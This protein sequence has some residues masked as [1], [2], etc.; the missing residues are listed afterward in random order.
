MTAPTVEAPAG[1]VTF[2]FT[3]IEGSTRLIHEMGDRYVDLLDRH[4]ELL[5][6]VWASHSGYEVHNDG[7]AFLVAFADAADGVR[8]CA[9]AQHRLATEPWPD[10]VDL[11]VRIGVHTG[12]AS[13]HGDDYV[14]L[15][16]HQAARVV[17]AAHGGLVLVSQDTIDALGSV[18]EPKLEPI[19]RYRLRDFD[20]PLQ[21]YRLTG[22][23]FAEAIP[24]IRAVPADGHNIV[25]L[26]TPTIGREELIAGIADH[27]EAGRLLTLIG[28]GGVGKTRVGAEVG[29]LIASDWP[30]GVWRVDLAGVADGDLVAAAI[31]GAIGARASRGQQRS[32]DVLDHL[33][34]RRA[35]V[36]LDNVEHV[37][38]ACR[39]LVEAIQ[40]RCRG[41]ALIAGSRVPIHV[42]GE[43]Q[44]PVEPLDVPDPS[45]HGADAVLASSSGRLFA[46]RGA[47]VRPGFVVDDNN[48]ADIAK[49]CQR[50][51]GLPLSLELA[52]THLAIQSPH[53]ILAGIDERFQLLRSHDPTMDER[54]RDVEGM[55]TWSYQSLD[56][57]ERT[58]FRCVSVFGTGFSILTAQAAMG[59]ADIELSEVPMLIWSLVD[60]SLVV[61]DLSANATRYRLLETMRTFGRRL[62]DEQGETGPVAVGVA[63]DLMGRIGPWFAADRRWLGEVGTEIDNLRAMIGFVPAEDQELAQQIA[64]TIGRYHDT[65]Q[66]F[67][68][69]IDELGRYVDTLSTPTPTRVSLLTT[70]ADLYLRT[71]NVDA[72]H[73]L[74]AEATALHGELGPTDWDDVGVDRTMGEVARRSGDLTGAIRIAR[75]TLERPLSDRGRSRM[76]NLLGTTSAATGEFETAYEAFAAELEVNK[77]LGYEGVVASA[78]GNLAEVAMRLGDIAA[79]ARHQAACLDLAVAQ[80]STTMLAFSLIVAA[81]IAGSQGEPAQATRLHAQGEV[82]LAETGLALYDDDRRRSDELLA[83]SRKALGDAAIGTLTAEGRQL[84]VPDAVELASAVFDAVDQE[85]SENIRQQSKEG[86]R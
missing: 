18:D 5:R 57:D 41:V 44:W 60:R 76:Y 29:M 9:D 42:S 24:A 77:I 39:T 47:A 59:G 84:E 86:A 80:G 72:A 58:A 45:Q 54:H 7:D 49:I 55:L 66:T 21:L 62:L 12:L 1:I 25:R 70:L 6:L 3:D 34:E 10:G 63:T 52:A 19:G 78:H 69:G 68:D 51:D 4:N 8:A 37:R 11:R 16:V 35:V 20:E 75:E 13:P 67:R 26:P 61:A 56:D 2:V 73:V 27:V 33:A 36:I 17:A 74:V 28:P 83:A 81:H 23:D 71:G 53:E 22:P 64:C 38:D 14:A 40:A 30:D 48:A 43:M 85:A 46:Q 82:L 79:A 65:S 15:A 50:L 31:A 32:E